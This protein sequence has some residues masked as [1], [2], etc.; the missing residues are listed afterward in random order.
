V[1]RNVTVPVGRGVMVSMQGFD[2]KVVYHGA[3][4]KD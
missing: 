2:E 4:V 1:K 3:E